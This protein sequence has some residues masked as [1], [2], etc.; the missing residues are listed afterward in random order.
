MMIDL[1]WWLSCAFQ[2]FTRIEPANTV[3][4]SCVTEIVFVSW[5]PTNTAVMSFVREMVFVNWKQ[6]WLKVGQTWKWHARWEWYEKK[7][8]QCMLGICESIHW[9]MKSN[10]WKNDVKSVVPSKVW[11][12]H[13][14]CSVFPLQAFHQVALICENIRTM[15]RY[16]CNRKTGVMWF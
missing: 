9:I 1:F 4:M 10:V 15:C 16:A 8:K 14:A 5:R 11:E 3:V 13:H 2:L 6:K 7:K 12:W